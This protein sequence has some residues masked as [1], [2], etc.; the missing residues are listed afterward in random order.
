MISVQAFQTAIG[1]FLG[2]AWFLTC[3][4]KN[5]KV[6]NIGLEGGKILAMNSKLLNLGGKPHKNATALYKYADGTKH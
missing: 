6:L 4:S 3:M 2:K 1:C 5:Q